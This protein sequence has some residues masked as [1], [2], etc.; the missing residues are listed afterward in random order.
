MIGAVS[1]GRAA[2]AA[3][4]QPGGMMGKDE[5]LQLLVAQL[6]NQD[7]INP[8][9]PEQMAA[10]LAQFSSV[11]QLMAIREELEGHAAL[12]AS[13]IQASAAASAVELVGR[14][15]LAAG[16]R[17]T[18]VEGEAV[19]LTVGSSGTGEGRLRILNA[20]GQVVASGSVGR[21][22][23]GR[24]AVDATALTEGLPSGIYRY[25]LEVVGTG[26]RRVEVQT[27]THARIEAVRFGPQ[28]PIL[29][30]GSGLEIA[31][32]TVVEVRRVE[33]ALNG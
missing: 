1:Q 30:S 14:E 31:L 20:E 24:N 33:H 25:E 12:Q 22:E 6:R 16:N 19:V 23:A 11:E 27:F 2:S 4:R 15:V 21:I 10:Q 18:L 5:F 29:I 7:P 9:N 3:G 32:S 28:G 13:A 26:N 8:M 17:F